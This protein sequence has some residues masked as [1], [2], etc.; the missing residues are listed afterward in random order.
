MITLECD[1]LDYARTD[2]SGL[3]TLEKMYFM[4]RCK[5]VDLVEDEDGVWREPKR[6]SQYYGRYERYGHS[7]DAMEY[8]IRFAGVPR[9]GNEGIWIN[10][11]GV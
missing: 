3:T 10:D 2:S 11:I 1:V 5:P 4:A 8:Y 7:S 6:G 9:T